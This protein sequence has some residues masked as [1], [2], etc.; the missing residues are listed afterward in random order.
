M[1]MKFADE[2]LHFVVNE[3]LDRFPEMMGRVVCVVEAGG[4]MSS[5]GCSLSIDGSSNLAFL[6]MCGSRERV[7]AMMDKIREM[8]IGDAGD[9]ESVNARSV[10]R[11]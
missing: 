4:K 11:S 1:F 10:V 6:V 5:E 3:A 7:N 8:L 2:N 9:G